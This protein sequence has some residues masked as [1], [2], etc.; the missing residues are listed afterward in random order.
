MDDVLVFGDRSGDRFEIGPFERLPGDLQTAARGIEAPMVLW[1]E[2]VAIGRRTGEIEPLALS[3]LRSDLREL[4]R[5]GYGSVTFSD[6]DMTLVH[7]NGRPDGPIVVRITLPDAEIW[8][9]PIGTANRGTIDD[10]ILAID[11]VA[12]AHGPL[13]GYLGCCG[14]PDPTYRPVPLD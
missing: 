13:T 6:H 9:E 11:A 14:R 1:R 2:G 4:R 10:L 12:R 3:N 8:W 7:L 5:S